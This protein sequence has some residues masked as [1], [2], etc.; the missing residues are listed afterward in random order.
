MSENSREMTLK[1]VSHKFGTFHSAA[2]SYDLLLTISN[3]MD[4]CG[5]WQLYRRYNLC[6]R[7]QKEMNWIENVR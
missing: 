1:E 6:K 3:E 2:R 5:W 7:F 4:D